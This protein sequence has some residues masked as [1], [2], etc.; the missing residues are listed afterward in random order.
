MKR[1]A[2]RLLPK[3]A[4]I[5]ILVI[6]YSLTTLPQLNKAEEENLAKEF[7]FASSALYEPGGLPP[8]FIRTV[9]PQ[10]Q[11]ISAWI[12]SVGAA[13]TLTDF[14]GNGLCN[15]IIHVD[16]RF[17]K[18]LISPAKGTASTYTP[19]VLSPQTLR[20]DAS[21][22]APMGTVAYDFN[23]DGF[24]DILVYYW[25]R[26]PIIFYQAKG[27]FTEKELYPTGER[28]FSNAATLA[29]F[30][31]DGN[32]DI[33]VTNYFPDG[34][35]VL[36]GTAED[37]GQVMQHSM[38]RADNGGDDHFFL[39]AGL[40]HN[41]AVYKENV[42]WRKDIDHPQDWTLAVGAADINNDQL[43]EIYFANDFGPDKLL[44]NLSTPGHLHFKQLK[45]V[46]HF[47]DIRS[48][49]LG[50]DSFK[51][52]GVCF[53]DIDGDGLL[54][55]YVSNIAAKYALEESHFVFINTGQFEK[56]KEGIAPFVNKSEELGLSRSSWGWEAR[57]ADFN[58]DGNLEALQATGFVKGNKNRWAEL[59]ELAIGN[60]ELLAHTS[61]WP[62][63]TAGTDLSGNVH[64]PFFVKSK[65][66]KYFDIAPQLGIAQLT[67]SRGIAVSDVDHD[68]DLDFV[69]ANQWEPSYFFHNNYSGP[70]KFLGLQLLQAINEKVTNEDH[71]ESPTYKSTRY[72][73]GA[74]VKVIMPGGKM[75]PGYVDGGNGHSG[76]NSNEVFFGLGELP[77]NQSV[78]VLI[79]WRTARGALKQKAYALNSGWHTI[80]LPN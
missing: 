9:H 65:S 48:G 64:N 52:M 45:G 57:L 10:Y 26:T 71:Q 29:D 12:S 79:Q 28:W 34:A 67:V 72:A 16:T 76:K 70:N 49:V 56:M 37:N 41:A 77:A 14:D 17:D 7:K 21:T 5:A 11:K 18:V 8:K 25:G 24:T 50:K 63:F 35:K 53:G 59:Q 20:Y 66:G 55:I 54:D 4:A 19:F 39:F 1:Y 78:N 40:E 61:V 31:G 6:L 46:R 32:T 69:T 30:D 62:D 15:D 43:P 73:I 47:T 68:G 23:A 42:E 27:G 60:D 74:S 3:I 80:V 38:T 58:N 44:Y 51:G 33:L 36:D 2:K 13:V 22:M 75:I